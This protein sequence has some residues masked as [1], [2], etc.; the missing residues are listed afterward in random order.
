MVLLEE[1][2]KAKKLAQISSFCG[3]RSCFNPSAN[4]SSPTSQKYGSPP[5]SGGRPAPSVDSSLQ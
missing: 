3:L 5:S 4:E 2:S 1:K